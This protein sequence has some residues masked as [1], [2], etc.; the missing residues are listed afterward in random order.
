MTSSQPQGYKIISRLR[1]WREALKVDRD[2]GIRFERR[3]KPL[4]R[5]RQ[6]AHTTIS[7]DTDISKCDKILLKRAGVMG[8]L[9]LTASPSSRR[10]PCS[11]QRR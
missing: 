9:R 11:T 8:S 7:T 4:K 5:D 6:A 3:S 10:M 1:R 2:S